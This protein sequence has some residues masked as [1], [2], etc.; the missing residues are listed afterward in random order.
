MNKYITRPLPYVITA[1]LALLSGLFSLAVCHIY[2]FG[3]NYLSFIDNL[4]LYATNFGSIQKI[5]SGEDSLFFSF[6]AGGATRTSFGATFSL[7]FFI[8]W[9]AA[10]IP[11]EHALQAVSWAFLANWVFISLSALFYFKNTFKKLDNASCILLSLGYLFSAFTLV[12][13]TYIP[14][15]HY[16]GIFPIFL[17]FLDRLLDKGKCWGYVILMVWIMGLGTY[18]GYMLTLFAAI[19]ATCKRISIFAPEH[20]STPSHYLLLL[21]STLFALAVTAW[22]WL[23]S[24]IQTMGSTRGG[25]AGK[26][27]WLYKGKILY[28][29]FY[30][31]LCVP[32]ALALL[33]C[34]RNWSRR[35][36]R[37]PYFGAFLFLSFCTVFSISHCLWHGG[38]PV[39]FPVRYG[40]M[41]HLM[42]LA[43]VASLMAQGV[44]FE[45]TRKRAICLTVAAFVL[46]AAYTQ[47]GKYTDLSFDINRFIVAVSV[48][49][50]LAAVQKIRHHIYQ[51]SCIIA[52][53][54]FL[55]S[56]DYNYHHKH[57]SKFEN[58]LDNVFQPKW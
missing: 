22:L 13:Y 36:F 4:Q 44:S 58:S 45:I 1:S 27:S 8:T 5:F 41:L 46:F 50:I 47:C 16:M 40:Y 49:F 52:A 32:V 56:I 26:I 11:C 18:G 43:W 34:V 29:H 7:S 57:L 38:P 39:G 33:L 30:L 12:K 19:Y 15:Y 37:S 48:V 28:E 17:Y 14:F 20:R 3:E 25:M 23:P 51:Y 55:F 54:A 53:T 6:S 9:L 10:F 35:L 31:V 21:W 24:L 2:P 42:L